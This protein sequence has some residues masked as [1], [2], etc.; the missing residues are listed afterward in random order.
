M[1][2]EIFDH[3]TDANSNKSNFFKIEK[4]RSAC[5]CIVCHLQ[6]KKHQCIALI[7]VVNSN[8]LFIFAPTPT[9]Y[10]VLRVLK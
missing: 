7:I 8:K 1:C 9:T 3:I 2:N 5:Y 10:L 6:H 4:Q